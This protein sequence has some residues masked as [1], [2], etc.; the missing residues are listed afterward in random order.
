LQVQETG[1]VRA[2]DILGGATEK[3]KQLLEAAIEGLKGNIDKGID[4]VKNPP[5]K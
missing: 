3:E 2:I 1:A 4:F 5:Q